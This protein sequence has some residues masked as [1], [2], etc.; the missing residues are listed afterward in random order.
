[1]KGYSGFQ[2]QRNEGSYLTVPPVGAYEGVIQKARYIEGDANHADVIELFC[3]I[4]DGEYKGRYMELFTDQKERFGDNVQYKGLYRLYVPTEN[5]EAWKKKNF[6]H[7]IWAVE[8]SNHGFHFDWDKP[9]SQ[10]DGKKICLNVR[11]RLY[12]YNGENRETTEIGRFESINDLKAGKVKELKQN[13]KREKKND[14]DN[15]ASTD[16]SSFTDVS[17]SVPVPW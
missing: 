3:D 15:N 12:T 7:D 8:D 14:A 10:L 17:A 13:D 6:E 16:S 5:D 11:T 4:T 2:A 1:M 9:E